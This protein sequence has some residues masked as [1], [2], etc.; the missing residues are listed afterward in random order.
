MLT[1]QPFYIGG[2][3]DVSTARANAFGAMILFGVVFAASIFGIMYDSNHKK[4]DAT[5]TNGAEGYQLNIGDRP[6][7]DASRFD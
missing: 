3:E 1:A 5:N 6:N 7:Y 2:I 4:E